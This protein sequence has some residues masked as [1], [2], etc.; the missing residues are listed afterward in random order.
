MGRV[1]VLDEELRSKI[2]AGEII[3]NPKSVVKELIENAIDA[4]AKRIEIEIGQG[5]KEK[6]MVS[7]DG[8][9][10]DR[11]DALQAAT[12]YATSKITRLEDLSNI[13][14]YGFRGEALAS[15]GAVARMII[16][17]R[18]RDESTS[19]IKVVVEA[20]VI[21]EETEIARD[22]GTTVTVY[23]LF[24]NLPVRKKFLK[25]NEWEK[26]GVIETVKNYLLTNPAIGFR[27]RSDNKTLLQIEPVSENAPRVKQIFTKGY[28]QL[29]SIDEKGEPLSV[30]GFFSRPGEVAMSES[31]QYIFVNQ[32]PV[33][34]RSVYRTI[35]DALG[36]PQHKPNFI[37]YINSDPAFVDVNIHPG[38]AE[39][40]FKDERYA[41]DFISQTLKRHLTSK[42]QAMVG[43][44]EQI[45]PYPEISDK[46]KGEEFWQLH[47]TYIIAQ[48]RSGMVIIDQ[49]V[50][51]ER[52]IYEG[53][54]KGKGGTQRLL[55]PVI[56]EL[57]DQE[58]AA[59]NK[60]KEQLNEMGIEAKE[61]SGNV[62]V[63]DT[64]PAGTKVNREELKNLFTELSDLKAELTK[65]REEIAKVVACKTALKAGERLSP[66]EMQNLID[67][68]FA[69]ENPYICPHGRPVI[70]KFTLEE[71]GHRFGRT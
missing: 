60:I 53:I 38:K 64:L 10:M 63:I 50:A 28:S 68:L 59:F 45:F 11:A 55:F 42:D 14:T 40:K 46:E 27:L 32:R 65:K 54:L 41:N 31:F 3:Q 2:A 69:C 9:G 49:H 23:D 39:V 19:G 37:I 20:G 1:K 57:D 58:F 7:D 70:I 66:A 24:F 56:I 33:Q 12:R 15:I 13:L 6:I 36:R 48:T 8:C 16:E 71:L 30:T 21:K 44:S 29:A 5:G 62:V 51:H 17:T 18:A 22:H 26:R 4:G 61:F 47:N 35:L 52:I 25:S 34:Y 67:R 43:V